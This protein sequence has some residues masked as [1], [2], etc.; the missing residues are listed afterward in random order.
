MGIGA[1]NT[2][3]QTYQSAYQ[4]TS[5]DATGSFAESLS[6]AAQTVSEKLNAGETPTKDELLSAL[7]DRADQILE[8]VK[9]GDTETSYQIGGQSFTNTEWKKLLTKF[10]GTQEKLREALTE[11]IEKQKEQAAEKEVKQPAD[12]S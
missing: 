4:T 3:E 10:D 9:N 2:K 8:K 12:A 7:S 6:A 11:R 1:I 5:A